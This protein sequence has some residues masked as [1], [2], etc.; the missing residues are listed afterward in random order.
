MSYAAEPYAQFVADLLTSLTGGVIRER[1]LFL[2]EEAPFRLLP[3][4]PIIPSTL[5][6]F[7]Q[8]DRQYR[9]FRRDQDF[10]LTSEAVV[11]WRAQSDGTPAAGAV[12][13]DEGT[14]FFVN[15]DHKGP[16][17]TG[18]V[19]PILTDR[20][21]GSVVRTLAESFGREYA[22]LSKQLESV[23][24]AGFIDTAGGRDLD[25]LVALV[26]V[27]RR[28][29]AHA[30]GA[31]VFGRSTPAD[32]DI[33]VPAGTRVST[34]DAPGVVFETTGDGTLHRGA[35]SVE[36]PVRAV[37][38]GGEGVVP[39][40]AIRVIHR[41]IHGIE[42]VSN[43]QGTE[44]GAA[45]ETDAALRARA[46]RALETAGRATTGALLGALGTLPG[47]REKDIHL[48]EDPLS[49]PGVVV[50]SLAAELE[51]SRC[52]DALDLIERT[53]PVGVRVIHRLE[54]PGASAEVVPGEGGA[55]DEDDE[56]VDSLSAGETLFR[57]V[58]LKA[59][60]VPAAA[61]LGAAERAALQ[62]RGEEAARAVV[63]EAG[64]GEVLVYNRVVAALMQI[65]GVLDVAVELSPADQ[66]HAAR[67]RNLVPGSTRRPT[68]D[69]DQ[70]G[71]LE[72]RVAGRLLALDVTVGIELVGAGLLGDLA[73]NMDAARLAV[74]AQLRDGLPGRSAI[75]KAALRGVVAG[76]E[77]YRL[78]TLEYKAEYVNDGVRIKD[79][80]PP[81]TLTAL[82]TAWIRNVVLAPAAP[83]AGGGGTP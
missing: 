36:L 76:N 33:A 67:R 22:V 35:L 82:E 4:G 47:V 21:P 13:P 79:Q 25:Q 65:E 24:E 5:V 83:A 69:P 34:G 66:P 12:W 14:A 16:S 45:D 49:R 39:P 78:T 30:G 53:R 1:F 55:P 77:T 80:S 56:T 62:K 43:P 72:V 17:P 48:G 59:I 28:T 42:S 54:C 11:E 64:V 50:L 73:A 57:P 68:V 81:V 29:R 31:V 8:V 63:G 41:P 20:N 51:A 19:T 40:L 37:A 18:G 2:P 7:G 32:A 46:K 9:R 44:L 3:P 15:Y 61:G 58:T 6:V 23:Y 60:L 52:A 10:V 75:S 38:G 71:V 74:A 26:G 27:E 70:G